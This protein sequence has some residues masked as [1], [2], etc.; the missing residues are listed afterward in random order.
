MAYSVESARDMVQK[1]NPTFRGFF[2][3]FFL[4]EKKE[5]QRKRNKSASGGIGRFVSIGLLSTRVRTL[6]LAACT[7]EG[8][9]TEE[10]KPGPLTVKLRAKRDFSLRRSGR[11]TGTENTRRP[12]DDDQPIDD[13]SQ[14][15]GY[16][17]LVNQNSGFVQEI[18]DEEIEEIWRCFRF[19]FSWETG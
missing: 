12:I 4:S 13:K 19:F 1:S 15:R 3:L 2:F 11:E 5:I 16:L 10:M 17:G 8:E 6:I 9:R 18:R 14:P 7:Q